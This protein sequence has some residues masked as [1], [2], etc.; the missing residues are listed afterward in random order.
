M[1]RGPNYE[2]N[3]HEYYFFVATTIVV[4]TL[5]IM[6]Q[7]IGNDTTH[8]KETKKDNTSYYGLPITNAV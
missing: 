6:P 7:V 4:K 1:P 2:Q 8:N 3:V 5:A